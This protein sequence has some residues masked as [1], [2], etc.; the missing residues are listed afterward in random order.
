[1]R[2]LAHEYQTGKTHGGRIDTLGID[3]TGSPVIIKD[4]R[5]L[6]RPLPPHDLRFTLVAQRRPSIFAGGVHNNAPIYR[7]TNRPLIRRT[8]RPLRLIGTI[9]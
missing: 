9:T 7:S 6:N 5:A 4:E 8:A 3:E 2:F 1:M